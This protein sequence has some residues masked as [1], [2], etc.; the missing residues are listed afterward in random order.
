MSKDP[1]QD[2]ICPESKASIL[3][4]WT[5]WWL[6]PLMIQGKKKPLE[7]QDLYN[8]DS[9][10]KTKLWTDKLEKQ[11][12]LEV[13]TASQNNTQPSLFK[14]VKDLLFWTVFPI[15][16]LRFV[17]DMG[18]NVAPIFI[19]YL[20]HF[21][22]VSTEASKNNTTPP[23][24]Y[25]GLGYAI[26]LLVIQIYITVLQNKFFH[27]AMTQGMLAKTAFIGLIFRKASRYFV[28]LIF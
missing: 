25:E 27:I 9:E 6:N 12:A 8:L 26:G 24:F 14:A 11:W 13:T 4:K 5:Y 17:S 15:G 18:T 3:S 19:N 23:S 20:V 2:N 16:F 1:K 7:K 10:R 28:F 21:V 22:S